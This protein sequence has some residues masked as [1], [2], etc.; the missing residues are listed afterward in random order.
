MRDCYARLGKRRGRWFGNRRIIL[1]G[2]GTGIDVANLLSSG[3]VLRASGAGAGAGAGAAAGTEGKS[4]QKDDEELR[5][6]FL[7]VST[8]LWGMS[9]ERSCFS[10]S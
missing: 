6:N 5:R 8:D 10:K 2:R 1:F 4:V 3:V 9:P 7:L